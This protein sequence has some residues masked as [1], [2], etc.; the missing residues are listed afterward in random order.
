MSRIGLALDIDGVLLRGSKVLDITPGALKRINEKKIPHIF[1]T[2]GGSMTEAKKAEDLTK[3]FGVS[4]SPEQVLLSHTPMKKLAEKYGDK[5]VFVMGANNYLEVAAAYGFKKVVTGAELHAKTPT[6]FPS[7]PP[8]APHMAEPNEHDDEPI[9]AA[10][11]LYEPLDWALKMQVLTDVLLGH[12]L[13]TDRMQQ[14]VP[15]YACNA[16]IVYQVS[17]PTNFIGYYRLSIYLSVVWSFAM[18]ILSFL[19]FFCVALY[20]ACCMQDL[21]PYPRFTQGAFVTAF[22]GLFEHYTNAPLEVEF[23][24]KPFEVQYRTAEEMIHRHAVHLANQ[25]QEDT[26][27][28]TSVAAPTKFYGIGDNPKADVRG[29]NNAGTHW[30]S[31]LV[32]TGVFQ[33]G[34]ND[35]HDIAD[36]VT[37]DLASALNI[38]FEKHTI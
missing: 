21:H 34:D 19:L 17:A 37:D 1:M 7:K 9:A 16:D 30:G 20:V 8:V 18:R 13:G 3:K 32:R 11:I 28:P 26:L 12:T 22:R 10:L 33:G 36:H 29:A 15:C 25:E 23:C 14:V 38:I 4:V 5:K 2:N 35:P 31:V 24:G 27:P 6:V